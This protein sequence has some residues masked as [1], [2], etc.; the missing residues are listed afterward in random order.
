MAGAAT[1][2][3]LMDEVDAALDE[4]N[5]HLVSWTAVACPQLD[6][7]PAVCLGSKLIDCNFDAARKCP[8]AC[9]PWQVARLFDSLSASSA[10]ACS[11]VLCVSHNAAFQQLCSRVVQLTRGAAGTMPADG[12]GK[13]G[14]SKGGGGKAGRSKKARK[15]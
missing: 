14:G 5:Q 10:V 15:A 3:F 11:Q 12:A 2:V 6:A 1:S 9:F 8:N 13:E 4:T 7:R